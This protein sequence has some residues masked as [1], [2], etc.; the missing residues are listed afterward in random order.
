MRTHL[1]ELGAVVLHAGQRPNHIGEL[2][3][4]ELVNLGHN[5]HTGGTWG[6]ARLC[7]HAGLAGPTTP[8]AAPAGRHSGKNGQPS[9]R[10]LS[11]H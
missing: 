3:G 1:H 4:L 6:M 5:L 8:A 10:L 9:L 2:L 11:T 7:Q